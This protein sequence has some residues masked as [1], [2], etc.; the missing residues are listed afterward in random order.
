MKL[1]L[2]SYSCS[3][4]QRHVDWWLNVLGGHLTV[5]TSNAGYTDE[6]SKN[7]KQLSTYAAEL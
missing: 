6:I 3:S 1:V 4:V 5:T 2:K 7:V